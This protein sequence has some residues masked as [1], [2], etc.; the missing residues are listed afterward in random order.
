MHKNT[1]MKTALLISTILCFFSC[2]KDNDSSHIENIT[3]GSK[4][5]LTIGSSPSDV[6]SELQALGIEKNFSSVVVVGRKPYPKPEEIQN[7]IGYYNA[8]TVESNQGV[9]DRASIEFTKD[10][11]SLIEAGNAMLDSVS[12]WP[13]D[14][15]DEQAIQMKDSISK[16]YQKLLG[17]FQIPKYSS[18][19]IVLP[20]KPL[21]KSFDPDMA[22]FVQWGFGF[23]EN[24]TTETTR[25][26]SITLF[27]ENNKLVKI[28]NYYRDGQM[29][30]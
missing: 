4:W 15:P 30:P 22:N 1:K 13:Q 18:Y 19:Q 25:D 14:L 10:T 21:N 5:T 2:T 9:V 6:Y 28:T 11:V 24:L 29:T 27:F 17:I 12:M 7:L 16:V 3:K 8:V 20:D 26:Y 23:S